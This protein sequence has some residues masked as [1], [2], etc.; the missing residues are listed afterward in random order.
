MRRRRVILAVAVPLAIGACGTTRPLDPADGGRSEVGT[1]DTLPPSVGG[2]LP[3]GGRSLPQPSVWGLCFDGTNLYAVDSEGMQIRRYRWPEL[4]ST[5]VYAVPRNVGPNVLGDCAVLDGRLFYPDVGKD[6]VGAIDLA[7]GEVD[8][9]FFGAPAGRP[10]SVAADQGA[11]W[12]S[13]DDARSLFKMS[14]D[15]VLLATIPNT[16]TVNACEGLEVAGDDIVC[17]DTASGAM[18]VFSKLDGAL[19]EGPTEVPSWE[20]TVVIADTLWVGS[21]GFTRT[22]G[23][24]TRGPGPAQIGLYPLPVRTS[25]SRP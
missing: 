2:T 7:T 14:V 19:L 10:R 9:L 4:V 6:V 11:L 22:G 24:L 23:G 20:G 17:T 8:G 15:G 3:D 18:F 5:A 21:N 25:T 16:A 12:V 13:C 1:F